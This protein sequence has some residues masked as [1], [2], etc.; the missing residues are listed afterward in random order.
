MTETLV[1]T[2]PEISLP[3][4]EELSPLPGRINA[5][6]RERE[7][8]L[9]AYRSCV[10][11]L[12]RVPKR[13]LE[14]AFELVEKANQFERE[15]DALGGQI[16]QLAT[17]LNAQVT[18]KLAEARIL[19]KR[20]NGNGYRSLAET[21][22]LKEAAEA[23]TVAQEYQ[24]ERDLTSALLNACRASLLLS[25]FAQEQVRSRISHHQRRVES[26]L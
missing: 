13:D 26:F 4:L 17:E 1:L 9:M 19:F 25:E 15:V 8:Q 21:P 12:G 11:E 20:M 24:R 23:M 22:V 7:E 16:E 14:Q 3:S 5:I 6:E 10:E 18:E 2:A